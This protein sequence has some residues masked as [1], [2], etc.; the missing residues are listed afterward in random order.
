MVTFPTSPSYSSLIPPTDPQSTTSVDVPIWAT[1][2]NQPS[3]VVEPDTDR[4]GTGWQ[5]VPDSQYGEIPPYQWENWIRFSTG[6][7]LGSYSNLL[8]YYTSVGIPQWQATIPYLVGAIVQNGTGTLYRSL[9]GT[10]AIPN[11]NNALTNTTYWGS[12][13]FPTATPFFVVKY[14]VLT[15]SASY[16]PQ[17]N[18]IALQ[19]TS[20]GSGGGG[21]ST[22]GNTNLAAAGGGGAAAEIS[23]GAFTRSQVLAVYP[24]ATST[25]I[26]YTIGVAVG[27]ATNGNTTTFGG[28]AIAVSG[29]GGPA[30]GSAAR[31]S[32]G[33]GGGASGPA[34]SGGSG[35]FGTNGNFTAVVAYGGQ[36]A[37][38]IYGAGGAGNNTSNT[39]V[40][41]GN[42]GGYGAGGGG[43]ATVSTAGNG[44][45]GS[46]SGGVILV[47][48]SG[49]G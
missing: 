8:S 46:S 49:Y 30:G 34:A 2:P 16:V 36:G 11:I 44:A 37:S 31:G 28:G 7:W 20:L 19:I 33:V 27:A 25:G 22:E 6:Q 48:E 35:I 3:D 5:R 14:T 24:D 38:S 21:G 29:A 18:F 43:G 39:P 15:S 4:M 47:Y 9:F 32:V 1:T 17:A 45:G 12:P 42:G 10:T 40:N 13:L 23:Y 26:P 41:G